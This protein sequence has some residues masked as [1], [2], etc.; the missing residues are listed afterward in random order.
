MLKEFNKKNLKRRINKVAIKVNLKK[1]IIK[2][3]IRIQ[4]KNQIRN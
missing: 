1:K 3:I 4:N 2:K